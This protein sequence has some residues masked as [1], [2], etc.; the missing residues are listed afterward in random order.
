MKLS[1]RNQYHSAPAEPRQGRQTPWKRPLDVVLG[2]FSLIALSPLMA[3]L[4]L[5]IRWDSTGP[6]LYRQERVGQ[7]GVLFEMWKFRSMHV[8]CDDRNH[9]EAAAV[10]F[11]G[12]ETRGRYKSE[13]DPRITRI[14]RILRRTTLDELPQLFNVL[15]GEMTL[16]GPRPAI[17]YE[18]GF[19]QAWYF[20]RQRVK[21]GMTGL[22]QVSGR[23]QLSAP[24]MMALDVKYVRECSPWLDVK[25]LMLTPIAIA[26]HFLNGID[27]DG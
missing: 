3:V 15:K 27:A 20:E 10:W 7:G 25:I 13:Q 26:T 14:G 12:R 21:P 9:R 18:V 17:P 5:L 24:E 23:D 1:G 22:W 8:W 2:T 6:A 19:Y 4:A 11:S 16:V